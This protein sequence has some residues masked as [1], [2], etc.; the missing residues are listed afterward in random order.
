MRKLKTKEEL[1]KSFKK[2][3]KERRLVIATNAGFNTPE[4]YQKHLESGINK[5]KPVIHNIHILDTSA[6]M[7]RLD[8]SGTH[9]QKLLNAV[10]G[11][12]KEWEELS[13]DSEVSYLNSLVTFHDD[14]HT[15]FWGVKFLEIPLEPV[16]HH[17]GNTTLYDTLRDVL[18]RVI[19]EDSEEVRTLVKIFTDG[20]DNRSAWNSK[21]IAKQLISQCEEKGIT[22]TFVGTKYDVSYIKRNLGIN[23]SNTLVHDNTEK[24]VLDSFMFTA[25]ATKSYASKVSRGATKEETLVGFY[26]QEGTL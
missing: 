8:G 1:L 2:A 15:E 24:A 25:N 7:G 11:M 6:S 22:I 10:K 12:K 17:W 14:S 3:N 13:N 20:M 18:A 4:D 19:R 21:A 23:E 16:T 9:G 5:G 26:K